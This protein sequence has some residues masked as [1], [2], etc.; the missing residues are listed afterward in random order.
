MGHEMAGM[1]E[2]AGEGHCPFTAALGGGCEAALS[3]PASPSTGT[4]TSV[5]PAPTFPDVLLPPA[6]PRPPPPFDPPRVQ[7][8]GSSVS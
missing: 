5:L 8:T 4:A 3:F 1:D 2:G 7:D 6:F